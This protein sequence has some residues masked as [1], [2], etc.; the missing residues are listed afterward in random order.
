MTTNKRAAREERF[1]H[2]YV[3]DLNGT[4]AAIAAGYA[5]KSAYVTAS[6]LLRKAKV[7]DRIA[8]TP[9]ARAVYV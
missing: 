6:R 4:R 5:E 2:E 7:R 8:A 3:R 1:V 9:P